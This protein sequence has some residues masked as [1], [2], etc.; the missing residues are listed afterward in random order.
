MESEAQKMIDKFYLHHP[1][2]KIIFLVKAGSHFFNLAGPKSDKDYRGIYLPSLEE[3][4]KGE[5]KLKM[6]DYKTND[7]NKK[8]VKILYRLECGIWSG[9]DG[10]Q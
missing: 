9:K 1:D 7:G 3:F 5:G 8:G 2:R 10:Q 6:I 4:Y